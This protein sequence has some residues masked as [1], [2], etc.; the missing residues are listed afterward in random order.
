MEKTPRLSRSQPPV[1]LYLIM[2][3]WSG[4]GGYYSQ[5]HP[6]SYCSPEWLGHTLQ[7]QWLRMQRHWGCFCLR[8]YQSTPFQRTSSLHLDCRLR[9]PQG[10]RMLLLL[11]QRKWRRLMPCRVGTGSSSCW[12]PRRSIPRHR[13]FLQSSQY[14]HLPDIQVNFTY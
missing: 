12:I 6:T 1:S 11:L 10:L 7:W 8:R 5:S 2:R 3:V 4:E 13:W 14:H 9:W